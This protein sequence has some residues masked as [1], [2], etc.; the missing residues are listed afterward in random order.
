[1]PEVFNLPKVI[2]GHD[3]KYQSFMDNMPDFKGIKIN[4]N[5]DFVFRKHDKRIMLVRG[6]TEE[7]LQSLHVDI[8]DSTL[9]LSQNNTV[10]IRGN[11]SITIIGSNN[12]VSNNNYQT[13]H[14]SPDHNK[15]LVCLSQS[16]LSE[17]RH[18]GIGENYLFDLMQN[19]LYLKMSGCGNISASGQVN[20]LDIK[21]SGIGTIHTDQLLSSSV[22]IKL[23]GNGSIYA[24]CDKEASAK[25]SGIGTIKISGKPDSVKKKVTGIGKIKI[26]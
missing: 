11:S 6:E 20:D 7:A 16:E 5:I 8:I 12:I 22:D 15:L 13:S 23:S 19:Y 21:L 24:N 14:N 2:K 10:S 17:F 26:L 3:W 1:M 18:S 4:G 9:I 25:V